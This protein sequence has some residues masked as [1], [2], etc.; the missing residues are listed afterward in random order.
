MRI[1]KLSANNTYMLMCFSIFL[2]IVS[3]CKQTKTTVST[4]TNIPPA[5][6]PDAPEILMP[7]SSQEDK[8]PA[9]LEP[10][11]DSNSVISLTDPNEIDFEVVNLSGKTVFLTCFSY[12]R[13][14]YFGNWHWAKSPTY[15]VHPNQT[16]IINIDTI[17]D[18]NDRKNVYGY[19]GVFNTKKDA[20]DA[21]IELVPDQNKLDLDLLI[22]LKGKKVTL[23]VQRYGIKGEFFEYDFVDRKKGTEKKQTSNLEF[24]VENKTGEPIL[25]TCFVYEKKAKGSWIGATEEKDDMTAWRYDKTAV[26]KIPADGTGMISTADIP[27]QRDRSYLRGYLAIFNESE[28]EMANKATYELLD[29]K[30]KLNVGQ[31][32]TL[33]NKKIVI[34]IEQYGILEDFFDFVIKPKSKIDFTNVKTS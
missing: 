26:I 9:P 20:D 12:E 5:T 34:D 4:C 21:T 16:E 29:T 3:G 23:E 18:D 10:K 33:T 22:N 14:H 28:E 13:R 19:L 7:L 8:T 17:P 31:L 6:L 27:T 30:R 11:K 15:Q 24:A 2:C 32:Q 25:V 1:S